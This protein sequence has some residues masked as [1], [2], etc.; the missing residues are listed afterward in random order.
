MILFLDIDGVMHPMNRSR[1]V[2][3]QEDCL[4]DVLRDFPHVQIVITSAWRTEHAIASLKGFFKT[5]L[6]ERIIG[7]TPDFAGDL[8]D[9][10][11]LYQR[12]KE[13]EFWLRDEGREFESW[14]ALDD[15]DWLFSPSCRRLL[16]VDPDTGF[17][18]TVAGALRNRL[19]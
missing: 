4:A 14:I 5:D 10:S 16:V 11:R 19:R 2:F 7:V 8:Q 15:A 12:E 18:D 1:G 9:E 6:K 17:D 3:S 13:I